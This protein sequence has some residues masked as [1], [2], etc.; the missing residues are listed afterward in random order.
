MEFADCAADIKSTYESHDA[1]QTAPD[2]PANI[3]NCIAVLFLRAGRTQEAW[4]V[5]TRSQ[6]YSRICIQI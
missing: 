6:V 2:W 3:L 5:S 1:R 4:W